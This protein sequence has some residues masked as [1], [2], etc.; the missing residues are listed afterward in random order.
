VFFGSA[1]IGA[2]GALNWYLEESEN[3]LSP[4]IYSGL[5]YGILDYLLTEF[6]GAPTALG[7]RAGLGEGI[8]QLIKDFQTQG[9]LETLLGPA[10]GISYDTFKDGWNLLTSLVTGDITMAQINLEKLARNVKTVDKTFQTM[11]AYNTSDIIT[12]KG[13]EQIRDASNAQIILNALAVPLQEAQIGFT[14]SDMITKQKEYTKQMANVAKDLYRRMDAAIDAGDM[15]TAQD[16]ATEI[17]TIRLGIQYSEMEEFN[18]MTQDGIVS[19]AEK[20]IIKAWEEG[21]ETTALRSQQIINE[22]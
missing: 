22:E 19:F 18:R 8:V 21:K 5:R 13:F 15:R 10:T 7:G 6:T 20:M 9:A 3:T 16:I 4:E 14:I 17:N 11:W 12:K 1:G 2:G